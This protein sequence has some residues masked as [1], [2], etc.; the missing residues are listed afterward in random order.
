[1]MVGGFDQSRNLA[2]SEIQRPLL[3]IPCKWSL[4][5]RVPIAPVVRLSAA[6][7][8]RNDENEV[9]FDGVENGVGKHM[10]EASPDI[11]L[12]KTKSSRII[13]DSFQG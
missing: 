8:D 6:V 4:L 5:A 13:G 11:I 10:D 7:H 3:S 12:K 9:R 2:L 1:M